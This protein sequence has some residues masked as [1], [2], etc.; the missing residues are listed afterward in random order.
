M[1]GKE[2]KKEAPD[3][4]CEAGG[5]HHL[6]GQSFRRSWIYVTGLSL[7][8]NSRQIGLLKTF[9]PPYHIELDNG[10]SDMTCSQALPLSYS[11]DVG[12]ITEPTLAI[13][14]IG[15]SPFDACSRRRSSFGDI[16]TQ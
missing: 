7:I 1:S 14:V 5:S 6:S 12:S 13:V 11:P 16:Y 9:Q 3:S 15:N 10:V 2:N 4:R 8:Y